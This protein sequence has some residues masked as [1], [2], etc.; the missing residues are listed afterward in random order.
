VTLPRDPFGFTTRE[1]IQSG[2]CPSDLAA[3]RVVSFRA[4]QGDEDQ[5][6]DLA[7]K[8]T[9]AGG[10]GK[11]LGADVFKDKVAFLSKREGNPFPHMVTIG[12]AR[13]SD[14]VVF[15][16]SVSKVHAYFLRAGDGWALVDQ[17]SRN[18]TFL[19]GDKV[20]PG[21]QRPLDDRA[22]IGL[23]DDVMLE[24]LTPAAV[25]AWAGRA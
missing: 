12:R 22:R 24:Y 2:A 15:A 8:S 6:A 7:F 11:T 16:S 19:N 21:Q 23:G 3:V 1:Q 20:E 18:G 4:P 13:N 10:Q 25:A 9:I 14:L 5:A 17:R